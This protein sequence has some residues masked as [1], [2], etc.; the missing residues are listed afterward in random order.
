MPITPNEKLLV[1]IIFLQGFLPFL[2]LMRLAYLRVQSVAKGYVPFYYYKQFKA[3]PNFK[4]PDYLDLPARNFVNLFELPV[5]FFAL[6]PLLFYFHRV[7]QTN[8]VLSALFVAF[9]Y[10]HSAIHITINKLKYR[11]AAYAIGAALLAV[12][13]IKF[14]VEIMAA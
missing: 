4:L 5:L 6:M 9:R 10:L 8:I 14:L 12:L 13:W 11:F 7:D 3:D 2:V 1:I